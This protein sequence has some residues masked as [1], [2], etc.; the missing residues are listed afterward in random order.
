MRFPHTDLNE[1]TFGIPCPHT[2][3][4]VL[5]YFSQYIMLWFEFVYIVL[6]VEDVCAG[7][8]F[9][10][11]QRTQVYKSQFGRNAASFREN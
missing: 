9:L 1:R 4:N 8:I 3:S 6:F 7:I 10:G 11:N 2:P 5:S